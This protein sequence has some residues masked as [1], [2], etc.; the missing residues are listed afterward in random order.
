[1]THYL[2]ERPTPTK[3]S[4]LEPVCRT[5]RTWTARVA[6]RHEAQHLPRSARKK[7]HGSPRTAQLLVASGLALWAHTPRPS[8]TRVRR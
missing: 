1:M 8:R 3:A 6:P 4:A 5:A 7:V 2:A